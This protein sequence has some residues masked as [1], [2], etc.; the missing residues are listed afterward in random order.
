MRIGARAEEFGVFKI[1]KNAGVLAGVAAL[2]S[3]CSGGGGTHASSVV[4][5][6]SGASAQRAPRTVGAQTYYTPS[7]TPVDTTANLGQ[8]R[9]GYDGNLYFAEAS[10]A[11]NC[12]ACSGRI[13]QITTGGS[14]TEYTLPNYQD[15]NS[16]FFPVFPFAVFPTFGDSKVWFLSADGYFGWTTTDGTNSAIYSLRQLGSD[17]SGTF[18]SFTQGTDSNF[19]VSET[20]P[21]RIIKVTTSGTASVFN[22]T[23]SS[24]ANVGAFQTNSDGNF[25]LTERGTGK[26]GK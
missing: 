23:L 24:G 20:S 1:V 19:Y 4:P 3:A 15:A 21:E 6:Q 10:H 26:I 2:L 22:S 17:T 12:S 16:N 9:G 18:T 14:I 25:W 11:T 8:I 5:S 7:V 13:S